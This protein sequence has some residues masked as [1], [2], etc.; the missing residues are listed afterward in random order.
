VTANRFADRLR[1][2]AQ[3]WVRDGLVT[4]E[5]AVRIVE[6]YPATPLWWW[7]PAAIFS[8]L[9]GALIAG[10][11]ALLVA[12]NW[13]ALPRWS[14][15]S[16]LIALLVAAYAIG[17]ALRERGRPRSGEGLFVVGGGLFLVG[18]ALVG[19]LYNLHGRPADALLLWWVLLVPAGYVLP[20]IA[21]L[22]LGWGGIAAWYGALLTDHTTWLGREVAGAGWGLAPVTAATGG[23][24]AWALGTL[25]GDGAYR[26][27]RQA[28]EQLGF[29][30]IAWT[31]I[32][33]SLAPDSS[34]WARPERAWPFGVITVVVMAAVAV[35]AAAR[36]LPGADGGARSGLI[37]AWLIQVVYLFAVVI[38]HAL[39]Q[40]RA[41]MRALTYTEW[42]LFFA[43]GLTL[44]VYGARWNRPAWINWGVVFVGLNAVTRYVELFGT[45]LET[46]ALFFATGVFVLALG[47]G[48]ERFRRGVTAR[49]GASASPA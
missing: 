10:A 21:L 1:V 11:V 41:L 47:W 35:G 3:G 17:I 15:L 45:M 40:P 32:V 16:G 9:G 38:S 14:K 27:V 49:A 6:R 19:Q 39:G 5:Q 4:P 46:S 34:S 2:E 18:I 24:L 13:P 30:T 25:H 43:F 33:L 44:V 7:R 37:A 42:A 8:V 48:L 20:S 26:R 22:I 23:I 29:V 12:H 36:R 28:L 31:S